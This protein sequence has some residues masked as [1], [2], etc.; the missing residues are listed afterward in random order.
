MARSLLILFDRAW[1][2]VTN[3]REIV[4]IVLD[5]PFTHSLVVLSHDVQGVEL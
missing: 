1:F 2:W 3:R 4:G 5:G